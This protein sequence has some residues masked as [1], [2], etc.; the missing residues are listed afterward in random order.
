MKEDKMPERYK[1]ECDGM[2]T[3]C[4]QIYVI[5]GYCRVLCKKGDTNPERNGDE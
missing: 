2:E 4:V 3:R 1:I 5:V